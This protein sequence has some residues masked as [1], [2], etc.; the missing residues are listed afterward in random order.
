MKL[1]A[2]IGDLYSTPVSA[3]SLLSLCLAGCPCCMNGISL[4]GARQRPRRPG[5]RLHCTPLHMIWAFP[6]QRVESRATSYVTTFFEVQENCTEL[7][8]RHSSLIPRLRSIV[9]QS[10][11]MARCC[12]RPRIMIWPNRWHSHV[13]PGQRA[14]LMKCFAL[15]GQFRHGVVPSVGRAGAPRPTAPPQVMMTSIMISGA[16]ED[17]LQSTALPFLYLGCP[18]SPYRIAIQRRRGASMGERWFEAI[19]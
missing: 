3:P 8:A 7:D 11:H 5:P 6:S 13:L 17:S 4:A 9:G 1:A 2:R 16:C 10:E 19:V 12:P 14:G 15:A 18:S